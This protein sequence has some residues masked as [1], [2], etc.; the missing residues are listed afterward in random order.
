M[1]RFGKRK[2]T[3]ASQWYQPRALVLPGVSGQ[4][5]TTTTSTQATI[6]TLVNTSASGNPVTATARD[7]NQAREPVRATARH[8]NQANSAKA[9]AH[10]K[11]K[12]A[13]TS[14]TSTN[15]AK[16]S[17]RVRFN[18]PNPR[19]GP[20]HAKTGKV[21]V[22]TQVVFHATTEA[23]TDDEPPRPAPSAPPG[24]DIDAREPSVDMDWFNY[25]QRVMNTQYEEPD[26]DPSDPAR[27]YQWEEYKNLERQQPG[28]VVDAAMHQTYRPW[29]TDLHPSLYT[30]NKKFEPSLKDRAR[31]WYTARTMRKGL[32]AFREL[33]K[34]KVQAGTNKG[35]DTITITTTNR[36]DSLSDESS[37]SDSDGSSS[38]GEEEPGKTDKV[39]VHEVTLPAHTT[40]KSMEVQTDGIDMNDQTELDD[41][42]AVSNPSRK[43]INKM[44]KSSK[45]LYSYKKL[46]YYLRCKYFMKPRDISMVNSLVADAR[47]WMIKSG[48]SCE[49]Q[50]D[51]LVLA[52]AVMGAFLVTEEELEFRQQ[53]KK[54]G[55]INNIVHLNNTMSGDL[56]K[57]ISPMKKF[58]LKGSGCLAEGR[59]TLPTSQTVF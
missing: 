13:T 50:D 9:I 24:P 47:V 49:T 28:I 17:K 43:V 22:S 38:D 55:L 31:R 21:S 32:K 41:L 45:R 3:L 12:A 58:K 6:S 5:Q 30:R 42:I 44:V 11:N 33:T 40:F 7:T 35:A 16:S 37:D 57:V 56:G 8:I 27:D 1:N 4:V 10:D 39:V 18:D 23:Q 26:F 25:Q 29:P 20:N 52:G 46:L 2:Q 54:T 34:A 48:R 51:Y 14:G 15:S 19:N 59:M 36:F 53:M